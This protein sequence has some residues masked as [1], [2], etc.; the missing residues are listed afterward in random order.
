MFYTQTSGQ[1]AT[2]LYGD[3]AVYPVYTNYPSYYD[4]EREKRYEKHRKALVE[5]RRAL[6]RWKECSHRY[7]PAELCIVAYT[8]EVRVRSSLCTRR[9]PWSIARVSGVR[10]RRSRRRRLRVWERES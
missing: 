10:Q 6:A 2:P 9:E 5:L 4:I 7:I 3:T 1:Y 8:P